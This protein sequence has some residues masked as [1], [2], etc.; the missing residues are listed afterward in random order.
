MAERGYTRG[1][2]KAGMRSVY[3]S[4]LNA[5]HHQQGLWQTCPLQEYL[6]DHT[7]GIHFL[8]EWHG[9]DAEATV[10]DY[11]LTQA[12]TGTAAISTA[13][14]GVLELDSN[15]TTSTQGATLQHNKFCVLPA[16]STEIW[17]EFEFKIVDTYDK[18]E[19]FVGLSELDTSLIAA[20]ANSSANHIGWECV[21]DNGVLVFAG[22][23]GGARDTASTAA[24]IAEATY[25]KVGFYVNGV[26]SIT[27]YI[28]GVVTGDTIA[29]ANIPVVAIY[30]SFVCQSAGTNDPIMHLRSYRIF[31][32]R[33]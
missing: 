12:T 14:G 10:G 25:I 11:V 7:I 13:E 24:T 23:K 33:A 5:A 20:S 27:Q 31:Q 30:P 1:W 15:S 26:T 9:Y 16:A 28:N 21:T 29:T 6:H 32:T 22:E 3:N 17:A 18:V 19:L 2:H 8:E 4:G